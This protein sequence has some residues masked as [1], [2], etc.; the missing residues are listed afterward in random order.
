MKLT[1]EALFSGVSGKWC[2]YVVCIPQCIWPRPSANSWR[3]ID[4]HPVLCRDGVVYLSL[5]GACASCSSSTVTMRFMVKNLLTYVSTLLRPI[6]MR[7][8]HSRLTCCWGARVFSCAG[9]GVCLDITFQ[10][11]LTL[12]KQTRRHTFQPTSRWSASPATPRPAG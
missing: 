2:N 9:F 3:S 12:S 6:M 1:E 7:D 5:I 10:K 8:F 11:W 4:L